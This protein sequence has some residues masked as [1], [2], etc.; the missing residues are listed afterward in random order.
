M[1]EEDLQT[2]HPVESLGPSAV[3]YN[4]FVTREVFKNLIWGGEGKNLSHFGAVNP[5]IT[6]PLYIN[7]FINISLPAVYLGKLL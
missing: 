3:A 4:L 2:P 5:L 7:F 1:Q 6:P